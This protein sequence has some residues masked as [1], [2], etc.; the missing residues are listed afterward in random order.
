MDPFT[1]RGER[2]RPELRLHRGMDLPDLGSPFRRGWIRQYQAVERDPRRPGS[3]PPVRNSQTRAEPVRLALFQGSVHSQ[4]SHWDQSDSGAKRP[5]STYPR[6]FATELSSRLTIIERAW[7]RERRNRGVVQQTGCAAVSGQRCFRAKGVSRRRRRKRAPGGQ[8]V[9]F[10]N[11][12]SDE[13]EVFKTLSG[14]QRVARFRGSSSRAFSRDS[15]WRR[16]P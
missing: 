6:G 5:G 4:P 13:G 1:G 7:H 2:S 8:A 15:R 12:G 3:S 11:L 16:T 10:A 14:S 9:S